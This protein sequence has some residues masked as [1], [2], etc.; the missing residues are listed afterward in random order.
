L[1]FYLNGEKVLI[2]DVDP[3]ALLIDYLRSPTVGYTGT[4][5]SCGEGGC[6][7]CTVMVSHFDS[8]RK[9]VINTAVNSCLRPICSLDGK[10]VT[11][12]EGIG[13][14]RTALDP[15]QYRVAADNG[16]QC[17]Y[18]TP[19]FV[20]NMHAFLQNHRADQTANRR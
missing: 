11:T 18:C 9:K 6:G 3:T 16:S 14:T 13:S 10:V 5:E 12:T 17:G 2:K 19:G 1:L 15:V 20:M 4:K 8:L 7:A